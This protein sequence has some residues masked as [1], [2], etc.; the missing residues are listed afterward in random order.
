M[1]EIIDIYSYRNSA[2]DY[3]VFGN[4]ALDLDVSKKK[5]YDIRK[6]NVR[7]IAGAFLE[8]G[9]VS[10]LKKRINISD[11]Y[12]ESDIEKNNWE[13]NQHSEA[14]KEATKNVFA[15]GKQGCNLVIWI[16]PEDE[17]GVYK[18]G[19]L[20]I[21]FPVFGENEWSMYGKHIPLLYNQEKMFELVRKLLDDGGISIKTI[22][23]IEDVRRQPIGFKISKTNNWISEC[24]KL[25]PEF[26]DIWDF[27]GEGK[28][29]ENK[30]KMEKE[31]TLAMEEANGNNYYFEDLMAKRGNII[32]QEGGCGSSWNKGGIG[33]IISV[34]SNGEFSFRLGNTEGLTFCKKCGCWYAGS[35]CPICDK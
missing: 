22:N 4:N 12:F 18:E 3:A 19:R 8:E 1:K 16:S 35:K 2:Q 20:N 21:E 6:N 9:V 33:M 32:N 7:E 5:F 34:N 15:L 25:M 28:D 23:E 11:L 17:D 31:V 26:M 29:V 10:D 14:E 30:L 13:Y 27:I 24:K